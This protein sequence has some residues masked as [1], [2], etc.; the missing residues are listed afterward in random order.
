MTDMSLREEQVALTRRTIIDTVIEL[1]S[2]LD[3]GP[4]TIPEVSR[5]SG[6][7]PATIY[8]HFPSRDALVSEAALERVLT[9]MPPDVEG[10]HESQLR[11][12]FVSLWGDQAENLPLA[13]QAT[14]TEAGRELRASRH[15]TL[16]PTS[17]QALSDAGKDP[18]TP[19]SR[20]LV[21]CLDVLTSVHAFL[22]LHDR[23]GLNVEEAVD[24]M[25]WGVRTLV[26]AVDL[27]IEAIPLP[28]ST[29]SP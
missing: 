3:A 19:E 11:A 4:I 8:R 5:R 27:P 24:A 25:L 13:R 9:W 14:V 16:Q 17:G 28:G 2:D 20:H 21:A 6:I 1:T 10:S 18:T 15:R 29:S 7:S 23:Q 22:D 12:Y 26:D